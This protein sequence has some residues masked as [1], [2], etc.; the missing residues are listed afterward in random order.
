MSMQ[1]DTR[2]FQAALRAWAN[3][4]GKD[5]AEACNLGAKTLIIEAAR[6]TVKTSKGRIRADMNRVVVARSGR[7][8]K[9]KY[10]LSARKGMTRAEIGEAADK[11]EGA[12]IRSAGYVAI[13]VRMAGKAFGLFRNLRAGRGWARDSKGQTATARGLEAVARATVALPEG[14]QGKVP[15]EAAMGPASKRVL[16]WAAEKLAKS[17]RKHSARR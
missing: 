1:V 5:A 6:G 16:G 15:W 11:K 12:R 3:A 8:G 4:A 7:K 10:L 13:C 9:R 2:E 17:A 14:T